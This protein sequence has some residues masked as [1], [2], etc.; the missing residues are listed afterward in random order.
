MRFISRK[1]HATFDYIYGVLV[2]IA[3]WVFGF[4]EHDAAT[5]VVYL[6][7]LAVLLLSLNTD[8]EGGATKV[9][10]MSFHLKVDIIGGLL[11]VLSPW[12]FRFYHET[13]NFHLA[14]GIVSIVV[15][16]C[17]VSRSEHPRAEHADDILRQR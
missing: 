6:W 4:S 15:G 14:A 3:P 16:L 12:L 13:H 2:I 7:G 17:T 1:H 8:Y 11:L 9:I 10:T 5:N